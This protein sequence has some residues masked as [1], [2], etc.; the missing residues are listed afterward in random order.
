[1]RTIPLADN[2]DDRLERR[3]REAREG[4]RGVNCSFLGVA[5]LIATPN[6][7][8]GSFILQA[9]VII[10]YV[11]LVWVG[12]GLTARYVWLSGKSDGAPTPS[13]SAPSS[14]GAGDSREDPKAVVLRALNGSGHRL[15]VAW[16]YLQ[17]KLG[18][19][20]EFRERLMDIVQRMR[21][22]ADSRPSAYQFSKEELRVMQL[23]QQ[24]IEKYYS[25][26]AELHHVSNPMRHAENLPPSQFVLE[27]LD[28]LRRERLESPLETIMQSAQKPL[29]F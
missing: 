10:V 8:F 17:E 26:W 18:W 9:L 2:E 4:R 6:S 27:M 13:G 16:D 15:E 12:I 22:Y 14:V 5:A 28:N 29:E 23:V 1:M 20:R 24:C 25:L 7:F 19:S 3:Y 11:V 21:G